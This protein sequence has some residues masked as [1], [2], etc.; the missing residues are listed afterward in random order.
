MGTTGHRS[1]QL[2]E[3]AGFGLA[4]LAMVWLLVRN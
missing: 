4:L 3:D 2:L 1:F